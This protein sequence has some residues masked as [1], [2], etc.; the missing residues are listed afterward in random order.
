MILVLVCSFHSGKVWIQLVVHLFDFQMTEFSVGM[1]DVLLLAWGE[2]I[3]SLKELVDEECAH[4]MG[5][6]NG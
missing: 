3:V 6:V 1:M 2:R 5:L 4:L